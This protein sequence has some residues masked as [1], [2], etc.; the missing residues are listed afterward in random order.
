MSAPLPSK[1][2]SRAKILSALGK[3]KVF[4]N[5]TGDAI[6]HETYYQFCNRVAALYFLN[7]QVQVPSRLLMIYFV[8]D[9]FPDG[10]D[11]PQ[12]QD[13]WKPLV[14]KMHQTIKL[15]P[16]MSSVTM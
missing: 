4:L 12:S 1:G 14:S 7:E 5:V 16:P 8:G 9:E 11:C 15:P 3:T 2:C 13:S 10:R 6:W